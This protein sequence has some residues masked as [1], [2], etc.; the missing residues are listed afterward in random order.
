[1]KTSDYLVITLVLQFHCTRNGSDCILII[2]NIYVILKC[3][4]VFF[5]GLIEQIE[6]GNF[7][8]IEHRLSIDEQH[9][10]LNLSLISCAWIPLV[11]QSIADR[12]IIIH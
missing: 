6:N 2:S 7:F 8:L 9:V 3:N 12:I 11:L 4:N 5:L 10:C 1:M